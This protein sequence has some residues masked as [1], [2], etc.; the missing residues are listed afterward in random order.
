MSGRRPRTL[1]IRVRLF[2]GFAATL[3]VCAALMVVII[4]VGI[5]Y[6]PTYDLP[7]AMPGH[8]VDQLPPGA[9]FSAPG[10]DVAKHA[11]TVTIR[12]KEDVWA[13][14]LAVSTAGVLVVTAIGLGVGWIVSRRLLA[15]LHAISEAA[16][17]AGDGHLHYRIKADGPHDEL[18]QLADT[19]DAMLSRLEDSFAAQKRFAANASHELLTPL[20]TTRAVLQVA[21]ADST[22]EEFAEF[23]PML[24]ETNER[25]IAV[26]HAL[27][28]LAEA[29][30]AVPDPDPVD[31]GA[32]ASRAVADRKPRAD[33][34]HLCVDVEAQPGCTVVGNAALLQQMALNLLDNALA[35]NVP[36]GRVR[37][38][39]HRETDD[40][41]FEIGNTG[42]VLDDQIVDRLFEPFYRLHPRVASDR[43][44]HGLGLAI[45]QSIVAAHDGAVTA[46]PNPDGGLTVRVEIPAADGTASVGA[47][48]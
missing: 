34:Q 7:T 28:A 15:P 5:R 14:V 21:T 2:L 18:R 17:K 29:E 11:T 24:V 20:T 1:S 8:L 10:V 36:D 4:Y 26:V 16:E 47:T 9:T 30:H 40:V 39:V 46:H 27:L 3:G 23:A 44:G 13:L 6:L 38:A 32:T 25:N 48:A 19:F 12:S 42:P 33:A 35:Y 45:V 43:S 37:V 22:G 31:L 41:V